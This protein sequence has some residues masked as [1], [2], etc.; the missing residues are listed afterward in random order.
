MLE[1]IIIRHGETAWNKSDIMR[2][3]VPVPLSEKGLEQAEKAG[4]YLSSKK[5]DAVYC[6]PLDRAVQTA[7]AIAGKHDLIPQPVEDLNDQH[8]GEWQG[9]PVAEVKEKYPDTFKLWQTRPD[10]V[11]IPGGEMLASVRER[12]VK[13][14]DKIMETHSEGAVAI[15]SHRVVTK[16]LICALLG[17]DN[18]HF[19]NIEHDTCGITTFQYH[20][21]MKVFVLKHHN[22]I[23]FLK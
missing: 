18:S 5:I 15:V 22:D 16:V 17:L 6:S 20:R 10:I 7:A 21:N 11:E 23:S 19:W 2:G 8:F 4:E 13:G 12:A 1:I 14:L 9:M 3:R